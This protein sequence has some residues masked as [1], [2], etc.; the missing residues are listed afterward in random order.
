MM[1]LWG[2]LPL[3]LACSSLETPEAEHEQPDAPKAGAGAAAAG[4]E[5]ASGAGGALAPPTEAG[6]GGTDGAE[7]SPA[8]GSPGVAVGG[9][10]GMPASAGQGGAAP[11]CCSGKYNAIGQCIDDGTV[12]AGGRGGA[13]GTESKPCDCG[14]WH[15]CLGDGC[16]SF[17]EMNGCGISGCTLIVPSC[18]N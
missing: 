12:C 2:I 13:A 15:C 9:A 6:E 8:S 18:P 16:S 10:G 1:R 7:P 14:V 17:R 11:F 4:A 3:V 5:N